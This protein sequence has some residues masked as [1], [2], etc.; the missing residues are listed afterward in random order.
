MSLITVQKVNNKI[1]NLLYI[2]VYCYTKC[3]PIGQK[4]T[5]KKMLLWQLLISYYQLFTIWLFNGYM[6]YNKQF[7]CSIIVIADIC[8]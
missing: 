4:A 7:L 6:F 8:I 2:I 3:K 1:Q 5:E